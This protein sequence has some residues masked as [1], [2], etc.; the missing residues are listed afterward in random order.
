MNHNEYPPS[1]RHG[2]QEPVHTVEVLDDGDTSGVTVRVWPG[3]ITVGSVINWMRG[4]T[5][6]KG[7]HDCQH[8]YD[9]CG[10]TR[11]SRCKIARVG[12][13]IVVTQ[14]WAMNY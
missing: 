8:L 1:P 5:Y 13:I 9:C 14:H 11:W 12:G 10:C 4:R 6:Y 3:N 7:R 2:E